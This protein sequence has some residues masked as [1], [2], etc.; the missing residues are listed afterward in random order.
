MKTVKKTSFGE[1]LKNVRLDLRL[2][3]D[4]MAERLQVSGNYI[5][6]LESGHNTPGPKMLRKFEEVERELED[7]V[8]KN[9]I[10]AN[11]ISLMPLRETGAHYRDA[12][13]APRPN[14]IVHHLGQAG[15]GG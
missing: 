6:L 3:Q 15:R 9:L 11:V 14:R 2:T 8:R 12:R 4:E 1:K 13:K 7:K 10:R 5:Y